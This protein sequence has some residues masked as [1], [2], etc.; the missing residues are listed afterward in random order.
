MAASRCRLLFVAHS[1]CVHPCRLHPTRIHRFVLIRLA[2][3][4]IGP[5]PQPTIIH[6][7]ISGSAIENPKAIGS[8][9]LALLLRRRPP[10]PSAMNDDRSALLDSACTS[11]VVGTCACVVHRTPLICP[12]SRVAVRWGCS[13]PPPLRHADE[14]AGADFP[15]MPPISQI[16]QQ[17]CGVELTC[18]THESDGR[19]L[20]W[21]WMVCVRCLLSRRRAHRCLA[22][23]HRT[24][25]AGG[26]SCSRDVAQ[27]ASR[28]LGWSVADSDQR[29]G[30]TETDSDSNGVGPFGHRPAAPP[31]CRRCIG[32]RHSYHHDTAASTA[33]C[34]DGDAPQR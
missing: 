12:L 32:W 24:P 4:H 27:T 3:T 30:C 10:L 17:T 15:P 18:G 16:A 21:R 6:R 25:A 26:A 9:P 19:I 8:I 31:D 2:H 28:V 7:S 34:N 29:W 13:H 5:R 1:H 23:R 14:A 11:E 33:R 20:I 22:R